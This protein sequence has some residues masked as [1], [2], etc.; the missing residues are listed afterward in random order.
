M[1]LT[2]KNKMVNQLPKDLKQKIE[3][4]CVYQERCHMEVYQKLSILKATSDEKEQLLAYLIE[5]NFLNEERF[6]RSFVRGKHSYKKWGKI[7]IVN[8]LK[9]RKITS[10]LIEIALKEIDNDSYILTFNNLA[11]KIW[12]STSEKNSLKKRKKCCDYLLRK[13]YESDLVYEKIKK[14]ESIIL[15]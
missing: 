10:K 8:E 6:A 14:L 12:E 3:Q 2:L 7:R 13:G 1:H 9:S 11:D 5:N 15:K 4:Y